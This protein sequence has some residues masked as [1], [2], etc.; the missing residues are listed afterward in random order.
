M[1]L[2]I[3]LIIPHGGILVPPEL[4]GLEAVAEFDI[5]ISSDTCANEIFSLRDRV[6][7][8]VSTDISRLFIDTD[9]SVRALPPSDTDGVMKV[10]TPS[11]RPLFHDG[12]FP[13]SLAMANM[14]RRYYLPF[15]DRIQASVEEHDIRFIVE[16]H[17]LPAVQPHGT[18][19]AGTP[20]PLIVLDSQAG[21]E[22]GKT[23]S[24]PRRLM[25]LLG[26]CMLRE[27]GGQGDTVVERI[28]YD[29]RPGG[30]IMERHGRGAIPMVR[31]S[32]SRSLFLNEEYWNPATLE[33]NT[34]RLRDI[35]NRV[36]VALKRFMDEGQL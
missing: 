25:H 4:S 28:R 35:R 21:R 6:A 33:V 1:S 19:D 30:H 34:D 27:F 14:L 7:A 8:I 32:L 24:C 9:R 31:M 11:G 10:S 13:D 5:F 22:E 36:S 2:P 18:P 20:N 29:A 17:T 3:L 12:I 23:S 16:C 15:H 26:D